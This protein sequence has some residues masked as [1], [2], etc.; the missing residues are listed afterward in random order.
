VNEGRSIERLIVPVPIQTLSEQQWSFTAL[1]TGV[2]GHIS[3]VIIIIIILYKCCGR[4]FNFYTQISLPRRRNDV[5]AYNLCH[6]SYQY[7][8]T[9]SALSRIEQRLNAH[10]I[11]IMTGLDCCASQSNWQL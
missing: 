1:I 3:S 2:F 8:D 9:A 4:L 11:K 7:F 5:I 10:V 6:Y